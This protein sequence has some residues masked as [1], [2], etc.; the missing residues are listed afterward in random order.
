MLKTESYNG[1]QLLVQIALT[2]LDI[3][4]FSIEPFLYY[5]SNFI[6]LLHPVEYLSTYAPL[7]TFTVALI[8][9]SQHANTNFKRK[10]KEKYMERNTHDLVMKMLK[11]PLGDPPP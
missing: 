6:I 5:F 2:N 4:C 9:N 10:K 3:E 8:R 1:Q 11:L 7:R